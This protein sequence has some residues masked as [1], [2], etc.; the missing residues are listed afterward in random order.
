MQKIKS[1]LKVEF[2]ALESE[3][4]HLKEYKQE[5]DLL[6]QEKM[7]HVEELRLIHADINVVSKCRKL[8][9]ICTKSSFHLS[10]ERNS[11]TELRIVMTSNE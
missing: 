6:L 4:K 7:A 10:D 1:R 5:M 11:A 2:E 9:W 3:E 8:R